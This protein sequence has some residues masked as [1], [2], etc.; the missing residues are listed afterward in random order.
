MM[1]A[2][3]ENEQTELKAEVKK[4]QEEIK[5]QEQKIQNLEVFIQK[6]EEVQHPQGT[7][8]LRPQRACKGHLCGSTRQVQR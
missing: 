2:T 5:V 6:G 1:S 7:H 3:Y 8:T 4:L